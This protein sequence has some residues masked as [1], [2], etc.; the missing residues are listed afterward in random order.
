MKH[1]FIF[2]TLF[3]AALPAGFALDIG[4]TTADL[5]SSDYELRQEAI[6]RLASAVAQASRP[7]ADP[8]ARKELETSILSSVMDASLPE[9]TRV[10][11]ARALPKVAS[12]ASADSLLKL[13]S[14]PETS[15]LVAENAFACLAQIPENGV[16]D[17]V[18]QALFKAPSGQI[19][20][21]W[22]ILATRADASANTPLIQQFKKGK[23]ELDDAALLSIATFG[24]SEMADYLFS[25]WK[26]AKTEHKDAIARTLLDLGLT[27][28]KQLESLVMQASPTLLAPAFKGWIARDETR[29]LETL[30]QLIAQSPELA[31]LLIKVAIENGSDV[32][33]QA[34]YSHV[35]DLPVDAGI[36]LLHSTGE[37]HKTEFE[38][39]VLT[40]ANSQEHVVKMAAI[41]C[42]GSIG[43]SASA[44]LLME[45]LGSKDEQIQQITF[46]AL[47]RL[48]EPTLDARMLETVSAMDP[49]ASLAIQVLAIRNSPGSLALIDGLINKNLDREVEKSM[50]E[51]LVSIGNADTCK[52][53]ILHILS[54]NSDADAKPYQLALKRLALR[55][56]RPDY[57]WENCFRP[58]LS[59]TTDASTQARIVVILDAISNAPALQYCIE[60]TTSDSKALQAASAQALMRWRSVDI[61]DF[62]RKTLEN[63]SSIQKDRTQAMDA[64]LRCIA[65]DNM[66][67]D[68]NNRARKAAILFAEIDEP[69]L[70][71]GL[72][73][74][75]RKLGSWPSQIFARSLEPY[76][77]MADY[78]SAIEEILAE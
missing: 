64:I 30:W 71:K 43:A 38:D 20:A 3:M 58:A 66:I 14:L 67:E 52:R 68:D 59:L 26:N 33:W 70:R 15:T 13:V 63:R 12:L 73:T 11:Y 57:L 37:H 32:T 39:Q 31:P 2:F 77:N 62:W 16:T 36:T 69:T 65:S 4:Q 6:D 74:S 78:R 19:A 29:A 21:Y 60:L 27:D 56:E 54:R 46:D 1:I 72:I 24:N 8:T 53:L 7:S 41:Q 17:Q 9:L 47:A 28:K 55:L 35:S 22:S 61:C 76:F 49:T 34:L 18:I 40:M 45:L 50:L 5:A 48:N 42:L 51:A 44:P 75:V 25:E 23:L 10:E